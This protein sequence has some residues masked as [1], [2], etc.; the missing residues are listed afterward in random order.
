[1]KRLIV[2]RQCTYTRVVPSQKFLLPRAINFSTLYIYGCLYCTTSA[3]YTCFHNTL[4]LKLVQNRHRLQCIHVHTVLC[5]NVRWK[6][7]ACLYRPRRDFH[8]ILRCLIHWRGRRAPSAPAGEKKMAR[9]SE[10]PRMRRRRVAMTL[11][12]VLTLMFHLFVPDNSSG[13]FFLV[14]TTVVDS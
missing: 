14:A 5:T 2:R 12:R 6:N 13:N 10:I 9:K 1:M 3:K 4:H 7:K 11:S 8:G